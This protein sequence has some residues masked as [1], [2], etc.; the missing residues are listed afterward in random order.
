MLFNQQHLSGIKNGSITLAFRKWKKPSAKEGSLIQTAIGQVKIIAVSPTNALEITSREATKAG[1]AS[2][3]ELLKLLATVPTGT[4]YK[5]RVAYHSPDPRIALRSQTTITNDEFETLKTKLDRLDTYSRE[6][7]WTR[8]TLMA[9]Q[10]HPRMKAA[11]LSKLLSKEKDWLKANIRKLK[12][13]GLT[14]SHD[15]GYE[16]APLGHAFLKKYPL[17][18]R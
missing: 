12:N 18:G 17:S 3:D 14:I 9:I 6:G 8:D 7:N 4:I 11:E 2:L 5:I 13:L 16:I 10:Q 1:F 15:P